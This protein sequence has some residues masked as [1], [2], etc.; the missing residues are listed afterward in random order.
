MRSSEERKSECR[1][2]RGGPSRSHSRHN[3]LRL[4]AAPQSAG[5]E[6][7]HHSTPDHARIRRGTYRIPYRKYVESLLSKDLLL[8]S[9]KQNA[10]IYIIYWFS[11]PPRYENRHEFIKCSNKIIHCMAADN[12]YWCTCGLYNTFLASLFSL[13][14]GVVLWR[15]LFSE[16]WIWA[17][18]FI[19]LFYFLRF[20]G[21]VP[22]YTRVISN[23][24][25]Y[26]FIHW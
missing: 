15:F 23:I 8:Q 5:E 18:F 13:N 16:I 17:T 26:T 10:L 25:R 22:S 7:R 19:Y 20:W 4:T 12:M 6:H 9:L 14:T 21:W 11:F 2:N 3:R 24:I 1:G